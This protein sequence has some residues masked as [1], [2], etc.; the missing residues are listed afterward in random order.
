VAACSI[1]RVIECRA[2]F[3]GERVCADKLAEVTT[4][5][6]SVAIAAT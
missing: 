2:H 1:L 4:V 3:A 5:E 6:E